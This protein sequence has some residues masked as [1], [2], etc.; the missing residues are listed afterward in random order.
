MRTL[1]STV[2]IDAAPGSGAFGGR[3]AGPVH[4]RDYEVNICEAL[5]PQ[6]QRNLRMHIFGGMVREARSATTKEA[7]LGLHVTLGDGWN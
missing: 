3:Y 6:D 2:H 4:M 1:E 5:T 7:Q